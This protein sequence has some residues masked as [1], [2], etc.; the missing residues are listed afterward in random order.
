MS[1]RTTAVVTG[2]ASGIGKAIAAR[3]QADGR[4]L[5]LVDRDPR[6]TDIAAAWDAIA[7]VGDTA[8]PATHQRAADAAGLTLAA[9]VNC[10]GVTRPSALIELTRDEAEATIEPNLYGTLWGCQAAVASWLRWGIR[11]AIVN[12]SS[13]H[14]RRAYPNH[15]VYEM[16]KAAIE[17]LTRNLA[18]SHA[19]DGIRV[20]A[21]APG[22]V[23]TP[24]LADSIDSAADPDAAVAELVDL[25]PA[26][27][28]AEPSEIAEAVAFLLS[29][30]AGYVTGQTLVVDG[31]MTVHIGFEES[32]AARRTK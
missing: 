12:I 22:A 29:D 26:G 3:L 9:W 14:G 32:D 16:T 20:N 7:V 10:A 15:A 2:A 1:A 5:V 8:D 30:K 27:R 23:L 17:A 21:V 19:A 6:L 31:G 11:G 13:V 28:L 18:V 25:I 4:A 24:A